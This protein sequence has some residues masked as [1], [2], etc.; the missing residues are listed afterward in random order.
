MDRTTIIILSFAAVYLALGMVPAALLIG[1]NYMLEPAH[2]WTFTP[3]QD[4]ALI[5]AQ[6]AWSI[7]ALTIAVKVTGINRQEVTT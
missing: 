1:A 5:A 6:V 3:A 4:V 2:A 7:A